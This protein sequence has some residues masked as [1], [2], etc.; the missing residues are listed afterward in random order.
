M[1]PDLKNKPEFKKKWDALVGQKKSGSSKA[2]DEWL[3]DMDAG[4]TVNRLTKL[5]QDAVAKYAK[6]AERWE[7]SGTAMKP[8]LHF[9]HHNVELII[10]KG[11]FGEGR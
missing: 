1:M 11:V 5:R 10:L 3:D 8:A 6:R 9:L 4:D 2:G 7:R